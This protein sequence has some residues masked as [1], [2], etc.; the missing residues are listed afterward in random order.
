MPIDTSMYANIQ[1]VQPPNILGN[2]E[3]AMK[4]SQLGMQN[5]DMQRQFQTQAVVKQAYLDNTDSSGNLDRQGLLSQLGQFNPQ[6]AQD[7]AN[8][9]YQ[10][11]KT[12]A[13]AQTA[14]AATQSAQTDAQNKLDDYMT[15][16]L[17]YVASLANQPDQQAAAYDAVKVDAGFCA[18]SPWKNARIAA[19]PSIGP[20][21]STNT[22]SS[23]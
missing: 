3:A 9:L 1:P 17:Q 23:A 14:Q 13:E 21:G 20:L 15:P 18:S 10:G 7:Q 5:A 4:L 11:D 2:A 19:L 22:A 8:A 16:K 12:K 6:V